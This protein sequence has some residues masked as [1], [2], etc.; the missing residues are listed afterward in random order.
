MTC[1][2]YLV[3]QKLGMVS[4]RKFFKFYLQIHF[5]LEKHFYNK[6][7]K[8]KLIGK[9]QM[10]SFDKIKFRFRILDHKLIYHRIFFS[11]KNLLNYLDLYSLRLSGENC[12]EGIIF[13][14]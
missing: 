3:L 9:F 14:S 13:D 8:R 2:G 7:S 12:Q 1:K 5:Y 10:V 11:L 6:K 4:F